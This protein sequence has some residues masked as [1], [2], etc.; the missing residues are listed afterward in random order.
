MILF[1]RVLDIRLSRR[2]RNSAGLFLAAGA[3]L[4]GL[5]RLESSIHYDYIENP[6]AEPDGSVQM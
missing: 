4:F 3:C 2:L 6:V 5:N 1:S